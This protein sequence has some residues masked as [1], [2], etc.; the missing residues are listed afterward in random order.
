MDRINALA[1][2]FWLRKFHSRFNQPQILFNQTVF[3]VISYTEAQRTKYQQKQTY[4]TC[5]QFSKSLIL[6]SVNHDGNS[7]FRILERKF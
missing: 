4:E 1:L 3:D 7:G 2:P 5:C 6:C